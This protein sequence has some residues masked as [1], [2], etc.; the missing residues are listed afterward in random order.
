MRWGVMMAFS[1]LE[2]AVVGLG[3]G[4]ALEVMVMGD[5]EEEEVRDMGAG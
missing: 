2:G 3:L 5:G 4:L 1:L